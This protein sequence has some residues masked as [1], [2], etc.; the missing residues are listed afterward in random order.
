MTLLTV[1][2]GPAR[3]AALREN[4]V[5]ITVGDPPE[6]DQMALE[7]FAEIFINCATELPI[8]QNFPTPSWL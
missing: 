5:D 1:G 7:G 6:G 8:Y 4:R 3:I 2:L